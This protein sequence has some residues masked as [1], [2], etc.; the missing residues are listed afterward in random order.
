MITAEQI[1]PYRRTGADYGPTERLKAEIAQSR[2][3]RHPFYLTKDQFI[4]ILAW[5]LGKQIGRVRHALE[6]NTE[7]IIRKVTELALTIRV[8]E[9]EEYELELHIGI[10]CCLRGVDV[11][12]ASAILAL[13]SPDEYAV[14][15]FRVW[16]QV[17]GEDKWRFTIDD[18]QRYMRRLRILARDLGWP[19]QEVDHAIWVY[20]AHVKGWV[21]D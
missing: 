1:I 18:Y 9:D 20:D 15:D 14:I 3:E 19:V 10:L 17:F 16:R 12:V 4:K 21:A 8:P 2:S 13:A 11:P 7:D 6:S 5:K